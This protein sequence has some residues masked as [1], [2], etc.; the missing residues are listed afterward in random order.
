MSRLLLSCLLASLFSLPATVMA[1]GT[2]SHST[3]FNQLL[4]GGGVVSEGLGLARRF[5]APEIG[6]M[7][8][9][10][11]PANAEVVQ[12]YLYW[13]IIAGFDDTVFVTNQ[14]TGIGQEFIGTHIGTTADT[15]WGMG[16][17]HVYRAAVR[18]IVN[19][20][21]VYEV[22]GFDYV[23]GV[24]D[25]QGF[26]IAV[27]YRVSDSTE[28]TQVTINDGAIYGGNGYPPVTSIATFD[29]PI[30]SPVLRVRAHYTVGDAQYV[31]TTT[32][33][34]DDGATRFN[35]EI[36]AYDNWEGNGC[37]D[38]TGCASPVPGGDGGMW[39]DDTFDLTADGL[40]SPGDTQVS[41]S[42]ADP[43]GADCLA[44]ASFIAEI[45]YPN[46]CPDQDL[47]FFTTCDGDCDDLDPTVYPG[48]PEIDD[49][50]DN[51]CN[52]VVDDLPADEDGDGFSPPTDCDDY[53][54]N[55]YPGATEWC[56]NG[57]DDDC[58]GLIDDEDDC[59]EGDD[60]DAAD[61][62]DGSPDDDDSNSGDDDGG[63]GGGRS[64][65]G[66]S[67]SVGVPASSA[68]PFVMA[69]LALIALRR[70]RS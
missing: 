13:V 64:R 19:A 69:W 6:T 23:E 16:D 47:D 20:N 59:E 7:E 50:L 24:V 65:G 55:V 12:A 44:F 29:E 61:D 2:D 15:C 41:A 70:R 67:C 17:N 8:I 37:S 57:I 3:T 34:G 30:G 33:G 68:A 53:D 54:D 5:G 48:A 56:D 10:G 31:A 9:A 40:V 52:G 51:D 11:I 25:N 66:C 14:A 39:D 26:S 49:G 27:V 32:V 28:I 43:Q 21:S 4:P 46:P 38:P 42:I 22:T 63:G 58:D 62:D 45:T 18:D 35:G 36:I 60:D 1:D